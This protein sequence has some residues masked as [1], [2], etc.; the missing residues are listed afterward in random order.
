MHIVGAC[1]G[2]C[3]GE[4]SQITERLQDLIFLKQNSVKNDKVQFGHL[5]WVTEMEGL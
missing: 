3:V 5:E 2:G 4:G 1:I